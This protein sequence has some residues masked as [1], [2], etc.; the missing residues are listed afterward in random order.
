MF[1]PEVFLRL[2]L[3][4]NQEQWSWVLTAGCLAVV[5]P[6]LA[7]RAGHRPR[8]FS[9]ALA[10]GACSLSGLVYLHGYYAPI[11]W[12]AAG[13]GWAFV[14][15][16]LL[17][18]VAACVVNDDRMPPPWQQTCL[19]WW[20]I[21]VLLLPWVPAWLLGDGRGVALYGLAPDLTVAGLLL[22]IAQLKGWLRWGLMV[23]PLIW[24][25]F[26]ILTY[27]ALGLNGMLALPLATLVLA[28][29]GPSPYHHRQSNVLSGEHQQP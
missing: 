14:V 15:Q 9:L 7:T 16:G 27:H 23:L 29:I 5:I 1:G 6:W 19:A 18:V 25:L 21:I 10:G 4:M 2:F 8:R 17:L 24:T 11:N 26:S 13:F 22:G 3:R 28:G 12:P 20:G